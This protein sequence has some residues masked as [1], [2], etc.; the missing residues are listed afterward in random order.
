M[1]TARADRILAVATPLLATVF[2]YVPNPRPGST[3]LSDVNEMVSFA[4]AS[5]KK[6]IEA[7]DAE[8]AQP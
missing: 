2:R 1:S 6:L 5:A 4:I 3:V 7:A 8:G